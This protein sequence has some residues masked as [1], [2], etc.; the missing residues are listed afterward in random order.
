[1]FVVRQTLARLE[2]GDPGVA[3]SVLVSALW[4][5]GLEK[6]LFQAGAPDEDK[7]GVFLEKKHQ[8]ERVRNRSFRE[9]ADF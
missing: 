2:R 1:M 4:V 5:L 7:A 3:L 6:Q 8:P 9:E